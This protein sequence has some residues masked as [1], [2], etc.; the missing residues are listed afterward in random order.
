MV[1]TPPVHA[2]AVTHTS[3][4]EQTSAVLQ[5]QQQQ[6]QVIKGTV[7]NEKGEPLTGVSIMIKSLKKGVTTDLDG[8]FSIPTDNLQ[9]P[10]ILQFFYV[11]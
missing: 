7:R 3:S 1:G 8:N 6:K 2:A 5:G 10:E 9:F 11:G 4:V